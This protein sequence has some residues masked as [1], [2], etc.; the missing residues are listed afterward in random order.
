MDLNQRLARLLASLASDQ[1]DEFAQLFDQG[2]SAWE[3]RLGIDPDQPGPEPKG[4]KKP[5]FE[6]PQAETFGSKRPTK[7]ASEYSDSFLKDLAAFG[8]TPPVTLEEL[9]KARKEELK[10]YHPDRFARHPEK[11]AAAGRIVQ[12]LGD[13]YQRLLDS[14]WV[15]K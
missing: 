11:S 4:P 13:T 15:K 12:I 7:S 14:P 1:L 10:K 9:K 6:R 8:L 2:L 3:R 5:N